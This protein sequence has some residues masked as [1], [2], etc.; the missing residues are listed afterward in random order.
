M[1]VYPYMS[2][3]KT[4][5]QDGLTIEQSAADLRLPLAKVYVELGELELAEE[6]VTEIMDDYPGDLTP[7]TLYAKIKHIRGQI[8][9]AI[10]SWAQ[11]HL[12]APNRENARM[13][14]S[15][16]L[17]MAIDPERNA[18]EFLALGQFSMVKK[19]SAHMDLEEV[20][21]LFV[22]RQ[23]EESLEACQNVIDEHGASDRQILKLGYLSKAF[24]FENLGQLDQAAAVLEEL[25]GLK[26][27]ASDM[28]RL[29]MQVDI[30]QKSEDPEAL[31]AAV[32]ILRYLEGNFGKIAAQARLCKI[33]QKLGESQLAET[34]EQ[35]FERAFKRRMHLPGLDELLIAASNH[36]L[37]LEGLKAVRLTHR[38][39]PVDPDQRSQAIL[40]YLQGDVDSALELFSK[41]TQLIDQNYA[42]DL[43]ASRGQPTQAAEL[44]L[45]S[46]EKD[47]SNTFVIQKL[48]QLQREQ[49][50][51]AI[52]KFFGEEQ[53][54]T[55]I[56][57]RLEKLIRRDPG[58]PRFWQDLCTLGA[59]RPDEKLSR[60]QD[61][62]SAAEAGQERKM[63]AI[64]RVYTAAVY[65]F[66]G[67]SKGL[68]HEVWVKRKSVGEGEG[69]VLRDKDIL[70]NLAPD[71]K[72]SVKNIFYAV[73]EY[74]KVK[75]TH[76]T[77]EL[78]NYNYVYKVTK[79]DQTS[80]GLSAGLPTALALLSTFIQRPLPQ[81]FS[82]S[83][84]LIT[85][86]H[87][88]IAVRFV[89]DAEYKLKGTFNR[90]LDFVLLPKENQEFLFQEA[91]LPR[92]I[93]KNRVR[94]V[95]NFDEAVSLVFGEDVWL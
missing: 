26:G 6:A 4:E 16:L 73:R 15:S 68:I 7:L 53:N 38:D 18:G 60:Y 28:D 78:D 23:V 88:Q 31:R 66:V 19:A 65:R 87:D 84:I 62:L 67:K 56:R 90:N 1:L 74:A 79:E 40:T 69:G 77:A 39:L 35:K 46:L 89:G 58:R 63:L 76:L 91:L 25:G 32:N 51:P 81:N 27:F 37:P 47:F 41:S 70:G 3:E 22:A 57:N 43:L 44:F 55:N 50:V 10:A 5:A 33:Y 86:S 29:Q 9:Q 61:R 82:S 13:Q 49:P 80:G 75:F 94:F 21:R 45:Q 8:S 52:E 95:E 12:R 48:M 11:L 93:I 30:L 24:I 2:G 72:E 59:I 83:G 92:Q 36:Y 14:I 17:Q 85:D 54:F 42:A 71:M 20:F 34:Y 64:G